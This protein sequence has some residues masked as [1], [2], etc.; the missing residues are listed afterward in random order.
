MLK[1]EININFNGIEVDNNKL[2]EI[3]EKEMNT[4]IG[5]MAAKAKQDVP[6]LTGNLRNNI[7]IARGEKTYIIYV[8][9]KEGVGPP[10]SAN[11]GVYIEF[12]FVR[13][14]G[15]YYKGKYFLT[16]A[17]LKYKEEMMKNIEENIKK[18]IKDI[19][20]INIK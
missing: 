14:N 1:G 11:Y 17:Y 13:S 10:N 9:E 16:N 7:R 2:I 20:S 12:G 19:V 8:R 15:T 3:V 6:V 18:S 5:K 4:S